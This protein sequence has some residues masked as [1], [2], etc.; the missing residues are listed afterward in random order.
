MARSSFTRNWGAT[1][2]VAVPGI[3]FKRCCYDG[4]LG[5]HYFQAVAS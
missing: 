1:T 3:G 2:C 5:N 4:T